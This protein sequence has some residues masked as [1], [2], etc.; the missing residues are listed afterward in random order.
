[1]QQRELGDQR[2]GLEEMAH[3]KTSSQRLQGN[4]KSPLEDLINRTNL[5][6]CS[7]CSLYNNVWPRGQVE[8]DI[9]AMF[10]LPSSGS[11]Q[12]IHQPR[13]RGGTFF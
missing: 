6:S 1:M 7:S 2:R 12:A 4:R 13:E 10:H 9:Q 11:G 8:T 3:G 5:Y